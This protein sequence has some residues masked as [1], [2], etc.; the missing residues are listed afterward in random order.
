M[1]M[2]SI[3]NEWRKR[4]SE[5]TKE[6]YSYKVGNWKLQLVNAVNALAMNDIKPLAAV[7]RGP[8]GSI[9]IKNSGLQTKKWKDVARQLISRKGK[10]RIAYMHKLCGGDCRK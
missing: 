3:L 1:K 2:K 4:L 7:L 8:A 6:E 9:I 10:E 5:Q